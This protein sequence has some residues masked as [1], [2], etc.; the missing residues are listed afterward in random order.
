MS[1]ESFLSI[2]I[3][4]D[5]VPTAIEDR[6][7]LYLQRYH[8][9]KERKSTLPLFITGNWG[10]GKSTSSAYTAAQ[11]INNEN[12]L[13]LFCNEDTTIE[14]FD[15]LIKRQYGKMIKIRAKVDTMNW[16]DKPHYTTVLNLV[17]TGTLNERISSFMGLSNLMPMVIIVDNWDLLPSR[18]PLYYISNPTN[19]KH[20]LFIVSGCGSWDPK[21]KEDKIGSPTYDDAGRWVEVRK[22]NI[23]NLDHIFINIKPLK[24]YDIPTIRNYFKNCIWN[25]KELFSMTLGVSRFIGIAVKCTTV[26]EYSKSIDKL[27]T[28]S[29]LRFLHRALYNKQNDCILS[30]VTSFNN[31]T[32]KNDYNYQ[33]AGILDKQNNYIHPLYE[34]SLIFVFHQNETLDLLYKAIDQLNLHSNDFFMDAIF[35]LTC[36]NEFE[37]NKR[38]EIRGKQQ[39]KDNKKKSISEVLTWDKILILQ[40]IN[41]LNSI[42]NHPNT[43]IQCCPNFPLF[44]FVYY[45]SKVLYG[46]QSSIKR[47]SHNRNGTNYHNISNEKFKILNNQ[48]VFEYFNILDIN[49]FKFVYISPKQLQL[50]NNSPNQFFIPVKKWYTGHRI[51]QFYSWYSSIN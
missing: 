23:T 14:T 44:D 22:A 6:I 19:Q 37:N 42:Q 9:T 39:R 43:L 28:E 35:K 8:S 29:I 16:L 3:I 12:I 31:R 13:V 25:N 48:T 33:I 46:F 17:T 38:I 15:A 32:I 41:E 45:N 2:K 7:K 5:F 40:D 47:Y 50:P 18:H 21:P 51:A 30:L 26:E 1:L 11:H 4:P 24:L 34:K 20:P 10:V 36:L 27:C 49:E